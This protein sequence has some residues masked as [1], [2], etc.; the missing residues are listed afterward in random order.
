MN[1][2]KKIIKYKKSILILFAGFIFAVS[3][4][5][6]ILKN[7]E[8]LRDALLLNEQ[9]HLLTIADTTA[10]SIE[11]YFRSEERSTRILAQ[12]T[13]FLRDFDYLKNNDAR[14][15]GESLKIYYKIGAPRVKSIQLLD[16]KGVILDEYPT[17]SQDNISRDISN[18]EDVKKIL[19]NKEHSL[20]KVYFKNGDPFIYILQPIFLNGEFNG[21]IRCELSIDN[22]YKTFIENI[23]SGNKGYASVKDKD[24]TFLM[25]PKRSQIGNNVIDLRKSKYPDYD[26]SELERLFE[27]QRSG[28]KGVEVY[29]SVWVTDDDSG[30]VRKFNGYAQA[31]IGDTFWIVT[32]SSDYDEVVSII[33]KNYYYTVAIAILIVLSISI[34]AAYIHNIREKKF[35]LEVKSMYLGEVKKLNT[36]LEKDIEK[37]KLLARELVKSKNKYEAMF[38]SI[39][40]CV[41][42]ADFSNNSFENILEMNEKVYSRLKYSRSELL[43]MKY[44]DIDI[45]LSEDERQKILEKILDKKSVLY[46]TEIRTKFN[47][48]IP[49]EVSA[50]LFKIEDRYRVIL[51]SR[52]ISIRKMQEAT[53]KRSEARFFNIVNKLATDMEGED[54]D[55]SKIKLGKDL[56]NK[57]ILLKLEKINIELE[58]MFKK[59]MD[60]NKKKEALMIYQSRY[61]AMGEM[62]GNIAHQWRQPLSSLSLI[63]SNIEDSFYYG[64][65]EKEDVETLF[66]K[67]R[68]LINKMSETIDDFRYFFKP[69]TDK[70]EFSV[71]NIIKSTVELFSERMQHNGIECSINSE[72]DIKILGYPNQLSQVIINFINNSVDA[73][74]ENRERERKID[75][76]ISREENNTVIEVNDN[77]GGI[78]EDVMKKIFEPYYSTKDKKNGTGIGLYMSQMIIEKNFGGTISVTNKNGGAC[79]KIIIPMGG[80]NQNAG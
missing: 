59:E 19:A 16:S 47:K 44:S 70:E 32:I 62:V 11:S 10:K 34:S 45:G 48:K 67:S 76:L 68:M 4:A 64:D 52:D 35:N 1:L 72:D 49:V 61:A 57:K 63:I 60:E 18:L 20:S 15:S 79:M 54:S 38:N 27:K 28:E 13:G 26:W 29:H 33:R 37:R 51:I 9:K 50:R 2:I 3:L 46:E 41:F 6:T 21:I 17:E 71:K 73:L 22:I 8:D 39:N 56:S 36:E 43:K 12:D 23:K 80:E 42:V 25:H 55:T 7:Y 77:G 78:P 40:D 31:Y 30:M 5:F 14:Y 66:K 53:V 65:V 24:G 69:K 58:K 74:L 75:I